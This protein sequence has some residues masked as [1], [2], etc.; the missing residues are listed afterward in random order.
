MK[1]VI[2]WS[3]LVIVL[4]GAGG[5]LYYYKYPQDTRPCTRPI[6]Y[7]IG[8]V[9]AR[10][11]ITDAAL[12]A[13][14]K[15]AVAIWNKAEGRPVLVYDPKANL[16]I[17]FIYDAREA[18]AK[19]GSD[20]ALQQANEDTARASLDTAQA[21]F[22]AEQATYNQEVSAINARGGATPGEAVA[23]TAER[24]SLN[25]LA[26]SINSEIASYNASV[27]AL[28]AVIAQYNQSAGH[29]FRE[30]EYV[31]DSAGQRINIFEFVGNTQLE[32]V[33]AHEFGHALGL[34]HNTDPNSIMFAQNESGNLVPTKADLAALHAVCGS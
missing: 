30:G 5:S 18:N 22:T 2:R 23:L 25:T 31:Q 33:L 10:F 27:A 6:P 8:A 17:N 14:S 15:V 13:D 21:R 29:T 20:I 32:R 11:G 1:D 24:E 4:V 28:N 34:G 19:L 3:V 7:A 9:D 16:K 12:L 26:N